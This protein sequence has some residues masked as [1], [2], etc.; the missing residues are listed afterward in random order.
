M[1]ASPCPLSPHAWV[2]SK[3]LS[4]KLSE[5]DALKKV[6]PNAP[7]APLRQPA[8]N[9]KTHSETSSQSS[10]TVSDGL[11]PMG[12]ATARSLQRVAASLGQL[13]AA[14]LSFEPAEDIPNGGVLCALPA[15][16]AFGLLPHTSAR[17]ALPKG[18][19]PLESIFLLLAYLALGRVP[20]LEHL[21]YS[22]PGE[23][24]KLLGLDRIPEVKTLR[25]KIGLLADDPARIGRWSSALASDWMQANVEAAGVLLAQQDWHRGEMRPEDRQTA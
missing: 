16:L 21:R 6:P 23:W 19:Y 7:T 3:I 15:L 9:V 18:F 12:V 13:D 17:F 22:S 8:S 20:S 10:R 2:F 14:P 5:T 4:T 25:E 1:M 24:G 11:N